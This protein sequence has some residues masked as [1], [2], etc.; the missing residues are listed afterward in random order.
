IMARVLLTILTLVVRHRVRVV[1]LGELIYGGWLVF[2]LR[3]IFGR[4]VLIYTHGEEISQDNENL[5]ARRRGLFL[6]H[7]HALIAVS[8][9]C[10]GQII[11]KYNVDPNKI[12]VINNGVDLNAYYRSTQNRDVWPEAIRN[13]RIILSVSRLVE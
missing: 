7:A 2:P 12:H 9:F 5:L 13:R 10:K 1:C 8:L 3:Y 4:T 6:H 11:S